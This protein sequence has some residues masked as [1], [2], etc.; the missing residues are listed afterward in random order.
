MYNPNNF[1]LGNT[2][3]VVLAPTLLVILIAIINLLL[4]KQ[5][6]SQ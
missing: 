5:Q 1:S 4:I 2:N 6:G 3:K